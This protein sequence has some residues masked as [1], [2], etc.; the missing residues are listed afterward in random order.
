MELSRALTLWADAMQAQTDHEGGCEPCRLNRTPV[1]ARGL[2][3]QQAAREAGEAW[4]AEKYAPEA[5]AP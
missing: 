5:V 2:E 4:A 1:C 3:L